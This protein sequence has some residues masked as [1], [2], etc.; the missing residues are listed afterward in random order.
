LTSAD[1]LDK[2]LVLLGK[3]AQTQE[4]NAFDYAFL[5]ATSTTEYT[6]IQKLVAFCSKC[7]LKD[8]DLLGNLDRLRYA[9]DS[10][11]LLFGE[12]ASYSRD[13]HWPNFWVGENHWT[14]FEQMLEES[15]IGKCVELW[16]RYRSELSA[17]LV[18]MSAEFFPEMLRHF[19][20]TIAGKLLF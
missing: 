2:L 17:F 5:A 1:D 20:R 11:R 7:H 9:L 12:Q 19:E 8:P 14:L 13:S 15:Q 3:L 6:H 18:E 4:E 16:T 10:Y